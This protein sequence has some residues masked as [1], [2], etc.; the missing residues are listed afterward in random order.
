MRISDWSSDVCSSD[1]GDVRRR[2]GQLSCVG[3]TNGGRTMNDLAQHAAPKDSASG[4]NSWPP[5][6][7]TM[8]HGIR[9]GRYI[10]PEFAKIE[11]EKLW[12]KTWQAG[13]RVDAIPEDD[14]STGT[15][16]GEKAVVN[17]QSVE[18]PTKYENSR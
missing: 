5:S 13:A 2:R 10:D 16:T 9:V 4:G 12:S 8:P 14:E 15:N 17:Q 6:W 7:Q 11:Y 3:P 18:A 1:L